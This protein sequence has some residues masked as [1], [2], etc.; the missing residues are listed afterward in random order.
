MWLGDW[1]ARWG[2]AFPGETALVDARSGARV[3]YGELAERATA[4]AAFLAGEAGVRRGD[5]VATLATNRLELVPLLLATSRLGAV[6]VPLSPRLTR[7]ELAAL[8]GD[9]RPRALLFEAATEPAAEKLAAEAGVPFRASLDP[10]DRAPSLATACAGS[11]APPALALAADDPALVIYTSG[12]TGEPKGVV[13]THGMILWNSVGTVLGWDLRTDDRT[14]L[15]SALCYT[16]GWNVLTLPLL[17]RRG[18]T[19]TTPAFD[20]DEVLELVARERLTLLFGVPTMLAMIAAS[21]RFAGADL[22][23]LRFV[24]TGGAP[25]PSPVR[26]AFLDRKGIGVREGYGLTEVGPNNFLANGKPGTVGHP[27]P[28]ARVRL[29]DPEGGEA[30]AGE[31]GELLLAGPHVTAGYLGRP[32][33][34]A[35]AL[36]DGW[37]RTGDLARID[38]D[39]H[40]AIVGR[41][42]EMLI[43]GGINVYPAEVEREIEA[44]PAVAAAA[45]IGVPDERWGEVGKAVVALRPGATLAKDELEAFLRGRLAGFKVPRYLARVEDLPRSATSGKVARRRVREL[46]GR[47]DDL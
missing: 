41:A 24:V 44:H 13:L 26:E 1:G 27:M 7:A 45:V 17:L 30:A 43:S 8:L 5:R 14:V 38:A 25:L 39:G 23:S 33:A 2:E 36:R 12:T 28:H 11:P 16:A 20:P 46:H 34:T 9:S 4:W 47:P 35:E 21:P 18:L 31:P 3:G 6:L 42:K 19:V 29:V 40:L 10:S 32:E 22:S 15:T 37:F